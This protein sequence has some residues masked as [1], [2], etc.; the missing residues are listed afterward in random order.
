M[1]N[2]KNF[3]ILSGAYALMYGIMIALSATLSNL[4]NPFGYTVAEISILG[5]H[6]SEN[7]WSASLLSVVDKCDER[8]QR[9]TPVVLAILT[10]L[11]IL[12]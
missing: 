5:S 3:L 7:I 10:K 4:L 6:A 9:N 1:W 8:C 11:V 12:Q 2:N